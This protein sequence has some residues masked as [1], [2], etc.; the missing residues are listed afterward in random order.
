MTSPA[1]RLARFLRLCEHPRALA[2][3]A[4]LAALVALPSLQIGFYADDFS[5]LARL[6]HSVPALAGSSPLDLYRFVGDAAER[7]LFIARGP[8]PWFT[9]PGIQLHLLRPLPSLS[10]ALDHLVWGRHAA[11]YHL[12]S[13]LLYVALVLAVG[14]FFRTLTGGSRGGPAAVTAT[15]ATLCFAVDAGHTQPVGWIAGRHLVIA[16]IPAALGLAAHVRHIRDGHRPSAFLAPL[17]LL[18][19][20]LCSEAGLGAVAYWL[21]FDAFGPAPPGH[22]A[23]RARLRRSVP[24]LALAAAYTAFYKAWGFGTRGSGAYLDPLQDPVAYAEALLTRLPALL[25]DA[26]VSIPS[27]L[28]LV[29]PTVPVV[30]AGVGATAFMVAMYRLVRPAIPEDERAA[31]RWL[32]P[33]ALGALL[34]AAGAFPGSRLLLFPSLAGAFLVAVLIHRGAARLAASPSRALGLGGAYLVALHLVFAPLGFVGGAVILGE[35]ARRARAVP[36]GIE[37]GAGSAQR[38]V[39]VAAS[40]PT[41]AFYA[42]T[43]V[44]LETPERAGTWTVLTSDKHD[45]RVTR[46]GPASLHVDVL[47]GR[48]LDGPFEKVLRSPRPPLALGDRVAVMGAEVTVAAV[49]R[50]APTAIDVTLDRDLDDPELFLLVWRGGRLSR[51]RPPRV[52]ESVVVAWEPGPF[53]LF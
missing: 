6:E 51:F 40:D 9:H 47:G 10:I 34:S 3:I 48:M 31:L 13:I 17:G 22:A 32:L 15:L 38:V 5:Q 4:V 16:A 41:V 36:A 14:R 27:D 11:G 21:A 33:G 53:G 19:A 50:G 45:H 49:D 29:F 52:G 2:V 24:A 26:F 25:A 39:V 20:L 37:I 35:I 23:P 30:V 42:A 1:S 12:T 46:T 43:I 7:A 18:F 44:A 28:S 8:L